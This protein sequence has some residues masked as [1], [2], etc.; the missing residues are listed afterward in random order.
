M[1]DFHKLLRRYQDSFIYV[2][3]RKKAMNV[4]KEI[5]DVEEKSIEFLPEKRIELLVTN[6][7]NSIYFDQSKEVSIKLFYVIKNEKSRKYYQH[8][9]FIT[10]G[11]DS[12][13]EDDKLYVFFDESVGIIETN[14]SLLESDVRILS[15]ITHENV[16]KKDIYFMD[17]ISAFEHRNEIDKY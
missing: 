8:P 6:V 9:S 11:T 12:L 1:L 4:L 3:E 17:Y 13:L 15:G 10:D 7:V 16:E 2:N 14:S 5:V